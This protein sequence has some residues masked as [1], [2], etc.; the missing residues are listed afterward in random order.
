MA[1]KINFLQAVASSAGVKGRTRPAANPT[2]RNVVTIAAAISN[3][4]AATTAAIKAEMALIV[5]RQKALPTYVSELLKLGDY[6]FHA[7]DVEGL[8]AP[9]EVRASKG[10]TVSEAKEVVAHLSRVLDMAEGLVA[11]GKA[12]RAEVEVVSWSEVTRWDS[13]NV[14][15]IH[16]ATRAERR[17]VKTPAVARAERTVAKVAVGEA[18][19]KTALRRLQRVG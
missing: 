17:K 4:I 3:H 9:K 2:P 19:W 7:V 8:L 18:D 12:A 6:S 11:A 13:I 1:R 16:V 14:A 5:E 15:P 10:A